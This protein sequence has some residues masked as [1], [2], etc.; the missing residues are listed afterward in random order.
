MEISHKAWLTSVCGGSSGFGAAITIFVAAVWPQCEREAASRGPSTATTA[1]ARKRAKGNGDNAAR[2]SVRSFALPSPLSPQK[3]YRMSG[4]S[5]QW[6]AA[7]ADL[8]AF[9]IDFK[10]GEDEA[11]KAEGKK[12]PN[13]FAHSLR[14]LAAAPDDRQTALIQD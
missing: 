14:F 9:G 10:R 4:G 11:F 6:A 2:R 8:N 3:I 1:R 12:R 13:D 7:A 5:D